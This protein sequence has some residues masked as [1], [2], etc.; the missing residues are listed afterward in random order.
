MALN[1][2]SRSNPRLVK[3]AGIVASVALLIGGGAKL[4]RALSLSS[5]DSSDIVQSV[6]DIFKEQTGEDVTV[7]EAAL[8][9]ETEAKKNCAAHIAN[10]AETAE[11]T[12]RVFWD[13][14]SKMVQIGEVNAEPLPEAPP[15]QS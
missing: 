12:Y 5:C 11:I 4:A 10:S 8:V 2:L 3:W 7:S 14:W 9:S 13:G 6:K 15:P 1:N